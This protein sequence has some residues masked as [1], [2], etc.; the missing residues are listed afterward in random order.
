MGES[1]LLNPIL[2]FIHEDPSSGAQLSSG[3]PATHSDVVCGSVLSS[4]L[5]A[6]SYQLTAGMEVQLE[7]LNSRRVSIPTVCLELLLYS[8][9]SRYLVV[10]F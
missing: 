10:L 4:G 6:S 7:P 9:S 8:I 5:A 1:E 2:G 3:F